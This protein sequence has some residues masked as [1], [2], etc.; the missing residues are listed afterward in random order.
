MSKWTVDCLLSLS[1][2]L[3]SIVTLIPDF[4][5]LNLYW[6]KRTLALVCFSF[7]F[8]F[9]RLR[10]LDKAEYSAFG[11]TLNSSVVSY[12]YTAGQ[13]WWQVSC[14]QWCLGVRSTSRWSGFCWMLTHCCCNISCH[15]QPM[16]STVSLQPVS[17]CQLSSDEC[18]C[19]LMMTCFSYSSRSY[20]LHNF[21]CHVIRSIIHA[22]LCV[23]VYCV[24]C[25]VHCVQLW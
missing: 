25:G 21:C 7:F 17:V 9:F 24:N 6:I 23:L 22:L 2:I 1:P 4:T 19:P 18:H 3:S 8:I 11:S 12:V 16:M 13:R 14:C 20:W 10:V 15:L 5:D